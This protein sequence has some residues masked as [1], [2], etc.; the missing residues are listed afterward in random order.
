MFLKRWAVPSF[1]PP[2]PDTPFT[3]VSDIHGCS[4][5]LARALDQCDGQ[6]ICVGDYIDRGPDSAGVLQMLRA[7]PDI[8]SLMGN[9]E[10]ML[11][12]FLDDPDTHGLRWLQFGGLESLE[13][14]GVAPTAP[15]PQ[16]RD[17]LRNALGP[18][19]EAWLR[20]LPSHWQSGNVAVTHAGADPALPMDQQ[21]TK[22]L[23]WGHPKFGRTARRDGVWVVRGHVIVD[24]PIQ[25]DG[26]IGIDTGA[27]KTGRLTMAHI[28]Q[29]EVRF[30]QV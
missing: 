3:A 21:P 2:N 26:I 1:N 20:A 29:G 23:R 19:N 12:N 30:K 27:Y 16:I 9:H 8:I 18:E 25:Q 14:F 6:I 4:D 10:E 24:D 5:L 11:L 22:A 13:S 28:G 7:R 17:A 15:L